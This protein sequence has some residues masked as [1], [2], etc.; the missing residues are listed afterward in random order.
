MLTL[1]A[2]QRHIACRRDGFSS[3]QMTKVKTEFAP[4]FYAVCDSGRPL[5]ERV[6]LNSMQPYSFGVGF[7]LVWSSNIERHGSAPPAPQE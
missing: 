4:Y 7:F 1:D 5:E 6:L 3:V 2:L